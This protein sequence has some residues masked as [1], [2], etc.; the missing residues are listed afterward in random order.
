MSEAIEN[1]RIYFPSDKIMI[2]DQVDA[3]GGAGYRI[4]HSVMGDM[5]LAEC[6]E[7]A[8]GCHQYQR[9]VL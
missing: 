7:Y 5:H 3:K 6:K 8:Y 4:D 9:A 1:V 2:M